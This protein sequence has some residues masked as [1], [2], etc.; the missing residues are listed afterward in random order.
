MKKLFALLL[1]LCVILSAPAAV[2]AEAVEEVRFDLTGIMETG[3][4]L[5]SAVVIAV[6]TYIARKYVIPW[7]KKNDLMEAAEIVVTAVEA[8]VGRGYG[9]K[10]WALALEKM[11]ERGY[12]VNSD[13]VLDALRVA[14]KNLDLTQMMAGEKEALEPPEE[15][16]E[17]V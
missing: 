11:K 1:S 9:E 5:I 17:E 6:I 8:L 15:E 13:A 4:A 3:I 2:L 14:W 7:L 10:K 16:A 12:D